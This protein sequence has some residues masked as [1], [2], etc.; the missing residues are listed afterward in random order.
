MKFEKEREKERCR[1][2]RHNGII[3]GR[4]LRERE[5]FQHQVPQIQSVSVSKNSREKIQE[6]QVARSCQD[7]NQVR[8]NCVTHSVTHCQSGSD[9]LCHCHTVGDK[10]CHTHKTKVQ[11]GS[12]NLCHCLTICVI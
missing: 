11:S 10:L 8:V 1:E 4:E 9:N 6:Y 5:G 3:K 12:D 7:V 2:R